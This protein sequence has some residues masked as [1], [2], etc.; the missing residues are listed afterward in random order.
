MT[1]YSITFGINHESDPFIAEARS[2]S[3]VHQANPDCPFLECN[4]PLPE[5]TG[6]GLLTRLTGFARTFGWLA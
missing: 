4:H 1:V 3:T 6:G 5:R 2:Y